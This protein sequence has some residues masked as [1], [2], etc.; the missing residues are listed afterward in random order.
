[1]RRSEHYFVQ[2]MMLPKQRPQNDSYIPSYAYWSRDAW[3]NAKWMVWLIRSWEKRKL[4]K[5]KPGKPIM[6][7]S[8]IVSQPK[9][10]IYSP[11]HSFWPWIRQCRI[12]ELSHLMLM[13]KH[14]TSLPSRRRIGQMCNTMPNLIS[15]LLV[16]VLLLGKSA[17]KPKEFYIGK[18]TLCMYCTL[19]YPVTRQLQH[20]W[21][22][23]KCPNPQ[24]TVINFRYILDDVNVNNQ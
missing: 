11:L 10:F 21:N 9:M 23:T 22:S 4:A 8:P 3:C 2:L 17:A 5:W 19:V 7:T 6:K 16:A 1:M 14:C 24:S 20:W 18:Q 12:S 15:L 13:Q